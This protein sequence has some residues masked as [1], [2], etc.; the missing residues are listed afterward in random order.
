MLG[1][2][3]RRNGNKDTSEMTFIDHLEALRAHI[4]RSIIAIF[5]IAIAIFIFR[6]W[7]FDNII[8]GPINPDFISYRALCNFSHWLGIGDVLCMPPVKVEMQTTTFGG[9]FISSITIAFVGGFIVAF[10]YVFWEFWRFI[11]PAL[12]EKEVKNT[13]F[14]IFWVSFFFFTGAAFGFFLLGPFT[15][16]F[17]AGFQLGTHHVLVTRP[18]LNDYIDNLVNILLGCGI[19]FELPVLSYI[20][21]K[22]GIITPS[23]LKKTRKYA[24]VLILVAAAVITPSPDWMSQMLVFIPLWMLYE[25]SII[26]SSRVFKEDLKKEQEEWG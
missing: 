24:V 16:N 13:R 10:P 17:L 9:Q 12:Q 19:A 21:T 5:L 4:V 22:I 25:I 8:T 1:F 3:N 20:L 6:D 15:F 26:I 23:F 11:K 7:V 14:A 2:L 18:T